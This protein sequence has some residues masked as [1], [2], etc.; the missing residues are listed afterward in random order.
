MI[1]VFR[2]QLHFILNKNS[3][4]KT[5]PKFLRPGGSLL[6]SLKKKVTELAGNDDV[7][8]TIQR[9]AQVNRVTKGVLNVS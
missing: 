9:A 6:G 2:L 5:I 3:Q 7:L 8:E 4:D 1:Y